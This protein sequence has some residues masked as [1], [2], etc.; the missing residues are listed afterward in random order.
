MLDGRKGAFTKKA[1]IKVAYKQ[2]FR[3]PQQSPPCVRGKK[4]KT[5]L[6]TVYYRTTKVKARLLTCSFEPDA[7]LSERCE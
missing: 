7:T 3:S 1:S 5:L 6:P 2:A 4:T